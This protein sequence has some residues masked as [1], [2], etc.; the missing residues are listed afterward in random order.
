M[1]R[2]YLSLFRFRE[3]ENNKNFPHYEFFKDTMQC[4]MIDHRHC[5]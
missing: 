2:Q 5:S 1:V 4:A 3:S